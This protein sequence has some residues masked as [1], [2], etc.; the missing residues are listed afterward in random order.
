MNILIYIVNEG[1][2]NAAFEIWD[3]QIRQKLN[4]I[5]SEHYENILIKLG[6]HEKIKFKRS[7]ALKLLNN[8]EKKFLMI[9]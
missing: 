7:D 6:E 4:K 5:K 8:S 9:F 1:I 2:T 3:K